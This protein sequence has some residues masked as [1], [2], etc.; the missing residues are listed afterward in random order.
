M[1]SG[2]FKAAIARWRQ[3]DVLDP[4][5]REALDLVKSNPE[6]ADQVFGALKRQRK[7]PMTSQEYAQVQ[8]KLYPPADNSLKGKFNAGYFDL[9]QATKRIQD[10]LQPP[11]V[12]PVKSKPSI[13]TIPKT[14]TKN[15]KIPLAIL[16]SLA[17]LSALGLGAHHLAN[18]E[19][20]KKLHG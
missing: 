9:E 8:S 13:P 20:S 1:S 18:N 3:E 4:Q 16:G 14:E 17:A 6:S 5:L 19:R 2:F 12:S 15:W 7:M 10:S 11:K